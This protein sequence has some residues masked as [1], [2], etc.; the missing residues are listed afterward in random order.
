MAK[1]RKSNTTLL[2]ALLG[3]LAAVGVVAYVY[4]KPIGGGGGVNIA[5]SG[6]VEITVS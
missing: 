5:P 1:K 4:A 6:T 3:G 2:L